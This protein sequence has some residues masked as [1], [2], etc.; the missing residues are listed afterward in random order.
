MVKTYRACAPIKKPVLLTDII[1]EI[2]ELFKIFV[3]SIKTA[4]RQ[5]HGPERSRGVRKKK[6]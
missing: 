4:D 6:N 2:E 5:A 1:R 3:A